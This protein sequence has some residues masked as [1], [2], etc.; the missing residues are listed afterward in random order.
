MCVCVCVCVCVKYLNLTNSVYRLLLSLA[1]KKASKQVGFF[2]PSIQTI[3]HVAINR[4]ILRKLTQSSVVMRTLPPSLLPH[5]PP[6]WK[7]VPPLPPLQES[8]V[9]QLWVWGRGQES[10]RPPEA[11]TF[12]D[13]GKSC[14]YT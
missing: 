4:T 5:S 1:K 8:P 13:E 10:V 14:K 12:P 9:S 2:L 7:T 3:V 6:H 11:Q